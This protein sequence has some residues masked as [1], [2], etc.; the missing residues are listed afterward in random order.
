[1]SVIC[2]L[3][4]TSSL[5]VL[6]CLNRVLNSH[7]FRYVTRSNQCLYPLYHVSLLIWFRQQRCQNI[8]YTREM[9]S[10]LHRPLPQERWTQNHQELL[11]RNSFCYSLYGLKFPPESNLKT[12]KFL[13]KIRTTFG[14]ID[15]LH[16]IPTIRRTIEEVREKNLEAAL[17]LVI[18]PRYSIPRERWSKYK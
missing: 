7:T 18:S 2:Y 14:W 3:L 15:S 4:L 9:N 17:L 16:Q 13:E 11:R 1:M 10:R 6:H 12:R 8:K 5:K